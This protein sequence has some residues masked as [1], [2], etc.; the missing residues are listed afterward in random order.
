MAKRIA[1]SQDR[2]GAAICLVFS[3]PAA[4]VGNT[5]SIHVAALIQL[6]K[7]SVGNIYVITSMNESQ[8]SLLDNRV[9]FI[10]NV[11]CPNAGAPILSAIFGELRAQIQIARG[12]LF[13]SNDVKIIFWRGRS[14]TFVLPLLLAR[15]KGKKSIL[16]VESK[17]SE[18][19]REVY[20]GLLGI[21]GFILSQ[22]YKVVENATHY[23]AD[24]LVSNVPSLPKQPW[25]TKYKNK[26]FPL[27]VTD[28]FIKSNFQLCKPLSHRHTIVGY[29]GRMSHEKGV[30]NLVKAIPLIYGQMSK[31]E[32]F[33]AGG[34][35][36]LH[37]VKSELTLPISQN[38]VKVIDWIPHDEI[39]NY[40]NQI[41]LLVVP[42]YYESGAYIALEAMACGTPVVASPVGALPDI[43][44]DGETGFIM[45]DNSPDC[46]SKN[47]LRALKH[48]S[49]EQIS[50]NAHA[51]VEEEYTYEAVQERW[52]KLLTS[53]SPE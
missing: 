1:A 23:L 25:L 30:L 52:H 36:L 43:I 17:G 11:A 7:P 5:T 6:V 48:P 41:K 33:L 29:I 28:N 20:Q 18:L 22:I 37:Q 32:F 19:V 12:L 26:V 24:T 50:Q 10:G 47:V 14:S 9:H 51:L 15:L 40:L 34:G 35:P 44:T 31:V 3:S 39:P 49:L 2:K 45:E 16:F 53:V 13:L 4:Q 8:D 21:R 46:I 38:Q 27:P 42:S